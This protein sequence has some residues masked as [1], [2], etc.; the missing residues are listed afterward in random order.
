MNLSEIITNPPRD[1]Y[2]DQYQSKFEKAQ[3]LV[4]VR[5]LLLKKLAD[6]TEI[7]YGLVDN[8]DRL[9]G[10][11]SLDYRGDAI[12]EVTLVQLAQAYKGQGYGTL[13][14]DY[15]VMNDKLKLMS[16]ATNTGGPHGSRALWSRLIDNARYKIVGYDTATKSIIPN[17]TAG[18]IY[19]NRPNTR[20]LA[21][22]SDETINES[23][24]R[25]QS[26]M[27]N[28]YVVWYGPGT[29]TEEYFNY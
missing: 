11:M 19:D 21:L 18:M 26:H 28:R 3:Q 17:A 6:S 20:W 23:L 29:T 4:T 13:L 27:K 14:Y 8:Q 24:E 1:E 2:L 10:Y 15:A 7:E 25:I 5:G 12:W 9:V 22:P 16:D